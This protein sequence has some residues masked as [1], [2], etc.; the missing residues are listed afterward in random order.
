MK[1]IIEKLYLHDQEVLE[2][3]EQ[4]AESKGDIETL[5]KAQKDLDERLEQVRLKKQSIEME[6]KNIELDLGGF[7]AEIKK[8]E[9][10]KMSVTSEKSLHLIED[11]IA[12]V[13]EKKDDCEM[14]WLEKSENLSPQIKM[15][16]VLESERKLKIQEKENSIPKMNEDLIQSQK[17]LK[18]LIDLRLDLMDGLSESLVNSYEKLRIKNLFQPVIFHLDESGCPKCGMHIRNVDFDM[19]RYHHEAIPCETC[20]TII[21]WCD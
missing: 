14:L 16:E 20:G 1:N 5:I 12:K 17:E 10:Q 21:Y 11:K 18:S 9:K 2:V 8:C 6:I 4:W 3:Y 19:I 13:S 7:E 15:I